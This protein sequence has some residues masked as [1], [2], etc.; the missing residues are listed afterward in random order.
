MEGR[1]VMK[2]TTH[3]R[4]CLSAQLMLSSHGWSDDW[5]ITVVKI[6]R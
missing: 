3:G 4:S 6:K 2:N 5:I 1:A